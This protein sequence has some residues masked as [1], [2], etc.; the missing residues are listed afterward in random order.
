MTFSFDWFTRHIPIWEKNLAP[1]KGKDN[2][3]FLEVGSFE[4]RSAHWALENILTG[5]N[6]FIT[7]IDT[8]EGSVEHVPMDVEVTGMYDRFK[9]NMQEH[10]DRVIVG[11]GFSYERL[12]E[13]SLNTF[14]FIYI[15]A[16]HAAASVLEDAVLSWR[17]L[18]PGGIMAFDDYFW[19][20]HSNRYH[21][22]EPDVE[23]QVL[24]PKM[25]I[26]AFLECYKGKYEILSHR[27]QVWIK[28]I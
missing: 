12:R 20:F 16:D 13:L 10:G 8:F 15:D 26:D 27:E 5:K 17:L 28:K 23:K 11:Q 9:E 19:T 6:C 4:G 2:L 24:E 3:K 18:K 14:D 21:D 1:F 22:L 25:A 7:C